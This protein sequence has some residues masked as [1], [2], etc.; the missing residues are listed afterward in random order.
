MTK[1][2][3]AS[4]GAYMKTPSKSGTEDRGSLLKV[5]SQTPQPTAP[6]PSS[7]ETGGKSQPDKAQE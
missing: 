1:Y 5:P 6:K 7:G 2:L 3:I 4:E